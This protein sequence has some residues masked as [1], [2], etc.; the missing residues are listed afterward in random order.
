MT[1]PHLISD[2][3]AS[4]VLTSLTHLVVTAKRGKSPCGREAFALTVTRMSGEVYV[5][6]DASLKDLLAVAPAVRRYFLEAR[7]DHAWRYKK[8]GSYQKTS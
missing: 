3:H 6:A 2:D 1:I 4:A 8:R 5:S 7:E